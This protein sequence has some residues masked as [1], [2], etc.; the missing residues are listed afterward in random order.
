MPALPRADRVAPNG[1]TA[2]RRALLERLLVLA[3]GMRPGERAQQERTGSRGRL[4]RRADLLRRA[5]LPG[6]RLRDV[7]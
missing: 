2:E 6:V 7:R 4:P 3:D 5:R 1:H